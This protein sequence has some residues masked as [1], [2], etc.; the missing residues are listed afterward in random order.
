MTRISAAEAEAA[1]GRKI[2]EAQTEAQLKM[3]GAQGEAEALKIKA[4]AEAEAYKAQAFA[5][6]EEMRA[7]GYTYQQ[8]TARMVGMEAMQNG[9]TGNGSGGGSA[10]GDI[11]GLGVTLGA[12]AIVVGMT[13]DALNP[14]MQTSA[15]IGSSVVNATGDTWN[16]TCGKTNITSKFC[17]ECGMA[18]PEAKNGWDC[19][20]GC[21]N[22]TSKFCPDCGSKKPEATTW[23]CTCG[24]KG[25]TSK[26]CPECGHKREE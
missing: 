26:F 24:C 25:I 10:L 19:A 6:A 14:I 20:C 3:V 22:I 21:K 17:P 11:A 13:R 12:L 2:L 23:D 5:E 15:D 1:H 16:C 9:I 8:E 4:Q 18:K 7:K